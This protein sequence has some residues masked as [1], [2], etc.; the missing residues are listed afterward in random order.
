MVTLP[1]EAATDYDLVRKIMQ[2]GAN[3]VR[4]NCAHDTTQSWEMHD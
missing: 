4:I 1:T 3:C 2:R